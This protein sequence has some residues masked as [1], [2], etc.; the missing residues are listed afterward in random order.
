M[1]VL[2]EQLENELEQK[3]LEMFEIWMMDLRDNLI[4]GRNDLMR[5]LEL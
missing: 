4:H 2:I 5:Q 3:I 1:I